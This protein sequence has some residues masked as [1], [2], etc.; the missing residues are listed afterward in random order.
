MAIKSLNEAYEKNTITYIC[1]ACGD[2]FDPDNPDGV[3]SAHNDPKQVMTQCEWALYSLY[4]SEKWCPMY[5]LRLVE[6]DQPVRAAMGLNFLVDVGWCESILAKRNPPAAKLPRDKI[7]AQYMPL[8]LDAMCDAV[9]TS[10]AELVPGCDLY[11]GNNTDPD[12]HELLIVVPYEMRYQINEIAAKLN[13][14]IYDTIEKLFCGELNMELKQLIERLKAV[15]SDGNVHP[16]PRCGLRPAH[17]RTALSRLVDVYICDQCGM[18]GAL[19]AKTGHELRL[20]DWNYAAALA[21]LETEGSEKS[22]LTCEHRDVCLQRGL[23]LFMLFI[24]TER[25]EETESAK[26]GLDI[27]AQCNHYKPGK[28][29][30]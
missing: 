16:C 20:D 13:D 10:I 25:Y 11:I 29:G 23:A 17:R 24:Q 12:G 1:N 3:L 18:D 22:C 4:W 14:V 19:R 28:K 6:P 8:M 27:S 9:E 7:K 5:V 26:A 30:V 15:Q 2:V 21:E